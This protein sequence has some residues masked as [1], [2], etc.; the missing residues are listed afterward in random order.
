MTY[1][2]KQGGCLD[3][4]LLKLMHW[5]Y[6]IASI[7]AMMLCVAVI[8]YCERMCKRGKA[9]IMIRRENAANLGAYRKE[10]NENIYISFLLYS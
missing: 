2:G 6:F 8:L 7:E 9:Q 1:A 10:M 4:T 5:E 3:L